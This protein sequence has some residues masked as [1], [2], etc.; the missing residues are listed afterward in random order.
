MQLNIYEGTTPQNKASYSVPYV[1]TVDNF[2]DEE[3][4]ICP[5]E[6]KHI[7][8]GEPFSRFSVASLLED[9]STEPAHWM[10]ASDDVQTNIGTG[11]S[12]HVLR[13]VEPTKWLERFIVGNKTVTQPI[14][15]D[16]TTKPMKVY[17]EPIDGYDVLPNTPSYLT[18][19]ATGENVGIYSPAFFRVGFDP[20]KPVEEKKMVP[21]FISVSLTYI[22]K[23]DGVVVDYG[24][25]KWSASQ[26]SQYIGELHPASF[27]TTKPGTYTLEWVSRLVV[28]MDVFLRGAIFTFAVVPAVA[29]SPRTLKDAAMS[30]ICAAETLKGNEG[31][32]VPRFTLNADI[33]AEL[34]KI[35]SPELTV[36]GATLREALD[37]IGKCIGA[38]TV[39]EIK[40]SDDGERFIYEITF[41]KYCKE[42]SADTRELGTPCDIYSTVSCEDYCTALDATVD[43]L[44][45]YAVGGSIYDPSP[46]LWRTPRSEDASYRLTEDS[47]EVFTA[48][49][50]ERIDGLTCRI[51][52]DDF[53]VVD[54]DLK[55]YLFEASEYAAL[56]SFS[57]AY[58]YTKAYALCYTLGQR[59]ITGL[60]FLLPHAVSQIFQTAAL[61][62]I[63]NK[64]LA[65]K[66]INKS[67]GLLSELDF[68]VILFRV[69]Y[70]PTGAARVRMRKPSSYGM[71]ESVLAFNQGAAKLDATAFGRGM[72]GNVLRMGNKQTTY[73]YKA[74]LGV[75]VPKK[76]ERFGDDGYVSEIRE[77]FAPEQK[78]VTITISDGF[79]RLSQ[80]VG[81]N[82]AQRLFE[83]S[84]RMS[85]DRHIVYEDRCLI[86]IEKREG[87]SGS[88]LTGDFIYYLR[89]AF[90]NIPKKD[91][92]KLQ[93]FAVTTG[94]DE[95]GNSLASCLLPCVPYGIGNALTFTVSFADNYGAGRRIDA[96][97]ETLETDANGKET[98][99]YAAEADVRYTDMFGRVADI[100]LTI[101][102]GIADPHM[103]SVSAADI[104][105]GQAL[106]ALPDV[107]KNVLSPIVKAEGT[108]R[109][110]VDKDSREAIKTL[111]YQ[112]SF[113]E[114]DGIKISPHFA[115]KLPYVGCY[116]RFAIILTNGNINN[117]TE[118]VRLDKDSSYMPINGFPDED[119]P[120]AL[121]RE[122]L[123][124]K[125]T[126]N[127]DAD[128]WAVVD[129]NEVREENGEKYHR[130]LFGK[131]GHVSKDE[132]VT[133]Y[134]NFFH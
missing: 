109:I 129:Y 30:M 5:I 49:P 89:D 13:L 126:A 25:R 57:S 6:I 41:E 127:K 88:I 96:Q 75:N 134:F 95:G 80:F 91:K 120:T 100:E 12:N 92:Q 99:Y 128:G 62:N 81:V 113:L 42:T 63:V 87:L 115:E 56:S 90:L 44:V 45:Q 4:D 29:Y 77:E 14:Y 33:A 15:N 86:S 114:T 50:I 104:S 17:P 111:T 117:L 39:L 131:N 19:Y 71:T 103:P 132:T 83:I 22:V 108:N 55:K 38:V 123:P 48:F 46:Q 2:L 7:P 1:V 36:T 9:E 107:V 47:A 119:Y 43:N 84:E 102:D 74:P 26:W 73:V 37:E 121:E 53:G 16:Y 118:W 105:N 35:T 116:D 61:V 130:F 51:Y 101:E 112:I 59:N 40:P 68:T 66:G 3:L 125:F 20:T 58:P 69:K 64:E 76:G 85:L 34:E 98:A 60:N 11:Y 21:G 67:Y 93:L 10:I 52:D 122:V 32:P 82:K 70:V 18:P 79:N 110:Y 94:F 8:R 27:Y 106:P 23:C 24:E 31:Q 28:G 72:F 133:V 54:L 78:T 65:E 124:V 97:K